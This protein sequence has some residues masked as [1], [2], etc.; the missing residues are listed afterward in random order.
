MLLSEKVISDISSRIDDKEFKDFTLQDYY[1]E[2]TKAN[3]EIA[4]KYQILTKTYNFTVSDLT[5]DLQSDI[6]LDIPDFRVENY[7]YANG[8]QLA[9]V[10]ADIKMLYEYVYYLEFID[11]EYHFN[12]R[13]S[14]LPQDTEEG[15]NITENMS[16]ALEEK[17]DTIFGKKNSA[18]EITIIYDALPD[19]EDFLKSFY[20]I[21]SSYYEEL[22]DIAIHYISKRGMIKFS[23]TEKYKKYETA[24]KLTLQTATEKNKT[25]AKNKEFIKLKPYS[26]I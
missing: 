14:A 9:K 10:S 18:D 24:F 25:A 7:V 1:A 4:R 26:I 11:N 22:V 17:T 5:D 3:R 13:L 21:P 6:I 16:K 15:Y 23:G 12:Y 19:G 2:F 8:I 20:E